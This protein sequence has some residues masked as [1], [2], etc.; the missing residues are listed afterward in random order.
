[1]GDVRS[2]RDLEIVNL[3]KEVIIGALYREGKLAPG[4]DPEQLCSEYAIIIYEN[5]WLGRIWDRIRGNIPEGKQII[6]AVKHVN[7]YIPPK[8]PPPKI[9]KAKPLRGGNRKAAVEATKA[10]L[11]SEEKDDA[12]E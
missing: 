4:V 8:P 1:M 5:S 9:K 7:D 12:K 3:A 2:I 10:K 11:D 6:I